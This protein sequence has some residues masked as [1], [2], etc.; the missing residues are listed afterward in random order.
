MKLNSKQYGTINEPF[1]TIQAAIDYLQ[2]N[3]N[4]LNIY[5]I[6]HL[7]GLV[8]GD[9]TIPDNF[10]TVF[11]ES[12]GIAN[13]SIIEPNFL[14]AG[15]FVIEGLT[16]KF[17][18]FGNLTL[19]GTAGQLITFTGGE[20]VGLIFNGCQTSY[21]AF[22]TATNP[23]PLFVFANGYMDNTNLDLVSGSQ[24][25]FIANSVIHNT[26]INI[27]SNGIADGFVTMQNITIQNGIPGATITC[28]GAQL[29]VI[30]C[31]VNSITHSGMVSSSNNCLTM[32]SSFVGDLAT[33]T[34]GNITLTDGNYKIYN[35]V[36]N[37]IPNS[38]I[39]L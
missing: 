3:P 11:I 24:L 36:Y 38:A 34:I 12:L 2:A 15:D 18:F 1:N 25:C 30:G 26:P 22:I 14:L 29:K 16:P 7:G 21:S 35:S 27:T 33:N 17:I 39:E 32:F 31:E 9:F 37:L 19:Q 28:G 6:I 23:L 4:P 8:Q 5:H 13:S 10:T 20:N